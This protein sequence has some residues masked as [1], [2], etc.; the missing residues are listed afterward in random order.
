MDAGQVRIGLIQMT[1]EAAPGANL[2]KA[3]GRIEEA[4]GR[5]AEV[6]CLQELYR[7]QYPCQSEK[8]ANF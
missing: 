5:G 3:Q 8:E 7:S 6:V 4:A 1:C 2:E